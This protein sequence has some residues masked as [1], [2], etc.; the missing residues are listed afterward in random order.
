MH[1]AAIT[2]PLDAHEVGDLLA[3]L[4]LDQDQDR[5]D[6][7]DRFGQH[8]RRQHRRLPGA[9]REI[10]LVERDVLDPDDALVGLELG[11]AIDQQ[12]GIA[13]GK[14]AFDRRIVEWQRDVHVFAQRPGA[15]RRQAL[16]LQV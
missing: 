16:N 7:G 2:D 15:A 4:R 6:L 13:M 10:P 1:R 11:D 12:E 8:R 5:A 3:V 9:M 14:D